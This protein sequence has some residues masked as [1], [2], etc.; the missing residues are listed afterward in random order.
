M[1]LTS[2]PSTKSSSCILSRLSGRYFRASCIA[3]IAMVALAAVSLTDRAIAQQGFSPVGTWEHTERSGVSVFTYNPDGTFY[4]KMSVPPGPYGGGSGYV[5]WWGSYGMA[6][7]TSWVTKIQGFQ[8]CASGVGCSSCPPKSGEL[9]GSN[10]CAV[11]Q[12]MGMAP[13]AQL[14]WNVQV[15]GPYQFTDGLGQT[16]RRVR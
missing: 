7:A 5:Q 12:S 2:I 4:G 14:Q 8:T 15:Q 6:G 1:I 16:W 9:P 10:A 3:V 13:G 11:A